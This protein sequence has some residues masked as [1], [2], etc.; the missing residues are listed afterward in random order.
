MQTSK[1]GPAALRAGGEI[2]VLEMARRQRADDARGTLFDVEAGRR[3]L[4]TLVEAE[5]SDRSAADVDGGVTTAGAGGDTDAGC[6]FDEAGRSRG[7]ATTATRGE[8]S[9]AR[10]YEQIAH[11][12]PELHRFHRRTFPYS[13]LGA[14]GSTR[15]LAREEYRRSVARTHGLPPARRRC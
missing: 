15:A 13:L 6:E 1:V 5:A 7:S 4:I 10:H 3:A 2:R 14:S 9:Q 11:R 8:R 12:H